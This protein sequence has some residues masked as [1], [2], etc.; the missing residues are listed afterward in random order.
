MECIDWCASMLLTTLRQ[1]NMQITLSCLPLLLLLLLQD[2]VIPLDHAGRS[3]GFGF[4]E[5]RTP[6]ERCTAIPRLPTLVQL[7]VGNLHNSVTVWITF[8]VAYVEYVCVH[9]SL[10]GG[11]SW[12]SMLSASPYQRHNNE[13][14]AHMSDIFVHLS[15]VLWCAVTCCAALCCAA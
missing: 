7:A 5:V 1:N 9:A 4:V 15:T 3:K 10:P 11:K 14:S 13:G 8:V 6:W 2:C 12:V